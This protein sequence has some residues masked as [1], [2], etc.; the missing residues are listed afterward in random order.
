MFGNIHFWSYIPEHETEK[1]K[2]YLLHGTLDKFRI[3]LLRKR[4][5]VYWNKKLAENQPANVIFHFFSLCTQTIMSCSVC[6]PIA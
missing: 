2:F 5:D 4:E 6:I 1:H 3:L